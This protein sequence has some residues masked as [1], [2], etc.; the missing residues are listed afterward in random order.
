MELIDRS[1]LMFNHNFKNDKTF[2]LYFSGKNFKFSFIDLFIIIDTIQYAILLGTHN[3]FYKVVFL[4][5][6]KKERIMFY[7]LTAVP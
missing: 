1:S 4:K 3:F 6:K 7:N 2:Y 5:R